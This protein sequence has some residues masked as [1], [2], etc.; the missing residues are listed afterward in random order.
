MLRIKRK[1][2]KL[3]AKLVFRDPVTPEMLLAAC[4]ASGIQVDK[5]LNDPERCLDDVN[6]TP[7]QAQEFLNVV[8]RRKLSIAKLALDEAMAIAHYALTDFFLGAYMKHVA[9]QLPA[10]FLSGK[11]LESLTN[12]GT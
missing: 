12:A 7:A 10:L 4:Q 2:D 3:T 11:G 5:F 8:L 9:G 1:K 6:L